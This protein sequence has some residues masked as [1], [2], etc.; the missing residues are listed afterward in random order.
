MRKGRQAWT[1]PA[2]IKSLISY[3][4]NISLVN[5]PKPSIMFALIYSWQFFPL[6]FPAFIYEG[7]T[8]WF[9]SYNSS[10]GGNFCRGFC[11]KKH[12]CASQPSCFHLFC[13]DYGWDK[14]INSWYLAPWSR[15]HGRRS[16]EEGYFSHDNTVYLKH[17]KI[18]YLLN[19]SKW[20][21]TF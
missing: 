12:K 5:E 8:L 1:V 7:L 14:W 17:S 6:D 18:Y 9:I 3:L 16:E 10:I 20:V 15:K 4:Q 2:H 11:E 21:N 19:F 13:I